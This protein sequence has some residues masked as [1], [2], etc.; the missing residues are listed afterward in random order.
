MKI[1]TL[2]LSFLLWALTS[3]LVF[4]DGG[5]MKYQQ[6]RSEIKMAENQNVLLQADNASL[7]EEVADLKNGLE[8]IEARARHDLGLV[9]EG[10]VFYYVSGEQA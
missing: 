2:I 3:T 7:L 9:K 10:E 5:L 1:S 6:Y 8:A 4:G